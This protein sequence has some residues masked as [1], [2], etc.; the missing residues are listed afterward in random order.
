MKLG[1]VEAKEKGFSAKP[2]FMEFISE[3]YPSLSVA[4][5]GVP[6]QENLA[7]GARKLFRNGCDAIFVVYVKGKH[8]Q[9]LFEALQRVELETGAYLYYCGIEDADLRSQKAFEKAVVE[10]FDSKAALL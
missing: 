7:L 4:S 6:Q 5:L 9:V 8:E 2:L 1:L 3:K 10:V